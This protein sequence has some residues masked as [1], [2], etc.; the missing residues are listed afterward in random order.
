ML[1][2]VPVPPKDKTPSTPVVFVSKNGTS[3]TKKVP[4]LLQKKPSATPKAFVPGPKPGTFRE[5][6]PKPPQGPPRQPTTQRVNIVVPV[7]PLQTSTMGKYTPLSVTPTMDQFK[8][9]QPAPPASKL[10]AV[11]SPAS[12]DL[13]AA[14]SG[15]S[16]RSASAGDD[17]GDDVSFSTV[18]PVHSSWSRS[19]AGSRSAAQP[20]ARSSGAEDDVGISDIMPSGSTASR[21]VQ[22]SRESFNGSDVSLTSAQSPGTAGEP[23]PP[24]AIPTLPPVASNASESAD[25]LDTGALPDPEIPNI[26]TPPVI[27]TH[28]GDCPHES[29]IPWPAA[30]SAVAQTACHGTCGLSGSL[31]ML[32]RLM[33]HGQCTSDAAG[34][35]SYDSMDHCSVVAAVQSW[36]T[37]ASEEMKRQPMPAFIPN[38]RMGSWVPVNLVPV[39]LCSIRRP[40]PPPPRVR[41]GDSWTC[42]SAVAFALAA[43]GLA[44]CQLVVCADAL[45]KRS[46]PSQAGATGR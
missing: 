43:R 19:G 34:Q 2:Q 45:N 1:P 27:Y 33:S 31:H 15:A 16:V 6:Q 35:E 7:G 20:D 18:I 42:Q 39:D 14:K 40:R 28:D 10:S 46:C 5:V 41:G 32:G 11:R 23:N 4:V 8:R 44:R 22:I 25:S 29:F 17:S 13:L 30:V 3:G 9:A 21:Y 12:G 24:P 36:R 26:D 37:I 38:N